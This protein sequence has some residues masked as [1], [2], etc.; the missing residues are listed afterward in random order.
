MMAASDMQDERGG[1]SV[2]RVFTAAT[3]AGRTG[4]PAS[5]FPLLPLAS[6]LAADMNSL[7]VIV[8][9]LRAEARNPATFYQRTFAAVVLLAV[10]AFL[11]LTRGL[12]PDAGEGLFVNLHVGLH[13]AI[14]ILVPV[15]A[16]DCISRERR[17]NTLGLL[18]LTP[19]GALDI[20]VAKSF[21]HAFR[22][23]LLWLAVLPVL[24]VPL[25][26]GG[27]NGTMIL[28][29]VLLNAAALCWA[30][31]AGLLASAFCR[32][33]MQA[34]SVAAGLG[35]IFFL[36]SPLATGLSL[37][38][39]VEAGGRM[40]GTQLLMLGMEMTFRL[41]SWLIGNRMFTSL[42]V[43]GPTS[44]DAVRLWS[45]TPP[46]ALAVL[47]LLGAML[48]AGRAIR[49]N[50]QEKP[51]S[52]RYLWFLRYFCEPLV[53]R[54]FF[55]RWIRR[56]LEKNPLGWL[57]QRSWVGRTAVGAWVAVVASFYIAIFG[58][59]GLYR[60]V[61][62]EMQFIAGLGLALAMAVVAAGSFRRERELGVM[63]LL[64]ITPQ[65]VGEI[66]LGRL[67]GIWEQFAPAIGLL[68]G[69]WLWAALSFGD[70]GEWQMVLFF[71]ATFVN[72][73]VTGLYQSL[74]ERGLL[75]ALIWTLW[76]V[77]FVPLGL[78]L[79]LRSQAQWAW[80]HEMP[81]AVDWLVA[82]LG[83]GNFSGL[84]RDWQW[85]LP[86]VWQ[87]ACAAYYWRRLGRT[88]AERSFPMEVV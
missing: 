40:T 12:A 39:A 79:L 24:A 30:L 38:S 87:L 42:A 81:W 6:T 66:A 23:V 16:A 45:C 33:R 85:L 29:S 3:G 25:L 10:L 21:V 11:A 5:A 2:S 27:V 67:K 41:D 28:C 19:L 14:W 58:D 74:R 60:R 13:L 64:L 35:M 20:V 88:L 77:L 15:M 49:L 62:T 32:S 59:I 46:A 22:A 8:R 56:K 26:M 82:G 1:A 43:A 78:S 48:I 37:L 7:P 68:L 57:E 55:K 69:I 4:A 86:A 83:Y 52:P 18:F 31:A 53:W 84:L 50:W 51:P 70:H 80:M 17:E 47:S 44:A 65:T 63:E 72:V 73:P 34:L 54:A 9:E 75:G 76:L 61:M 71:A 36:S